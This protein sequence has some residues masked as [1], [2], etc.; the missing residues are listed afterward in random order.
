MRPG[1]KKSV[2]IILGI[3]TLFLIVDIYVG[4]K[5][6]K[7]IREREE[8]KERL[9]RLAF[10]MVFPD[11]KDVK[12]VESRH[13]RYEVTIKV[14]NLSDDIVYITYPDVKTYVQTSTFWTEVPVEESTNEEIKQIYR[15][16]RGIYYFKKFTI[17]GRNINYTPY[18][19][20][21]YMHVRFHISFFVLP[22]SAFK[23]EEVAERYTDVYVYLKPYFINENLIAKELKFPDNKVPEM[24]P[25]PPH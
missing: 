14:E 12:N 21:Y 7:V 22:E 11:I 16:D 25:M 18:M 19:M 20:P 6:R 10:F 8:K 9:E 2:F 1:I 4:I 13:G 3:L 17:I 23:E 24:I 5:E 15:L